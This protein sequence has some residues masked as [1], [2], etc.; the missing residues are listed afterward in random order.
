[1]PASSA[2]KSKPPMPANREPKVIWGWLGLVGSLCCL[3]QC[4][5]VGCSRVFMVFMGWWFVARMGRIGRM[6]TDWRGWGLT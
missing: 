3:N 4:F 1:M 6:G 2:P 5:R